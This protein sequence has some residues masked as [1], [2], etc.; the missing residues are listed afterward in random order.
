M[1]AQ[2]LVAIEELNE[3]KQQLLDLQVKIGNN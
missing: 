1:R 2:R 3:K